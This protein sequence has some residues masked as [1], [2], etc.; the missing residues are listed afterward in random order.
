MVD[1]A[2]GGSRRDPL[3]ESDQTSRL[4]DPWP[5]RISSTI[6]WTILV[7]RTRLPLLNVS[8]SSSRSSGV[9]ET[10]LRGSRHQPAVRVSSRRGLSRGSGRN[11]GL[12]DRRVRSHSAGRAGRRLKRCRT[13]NFR[14]TWRRRPSA[15]HSWISCPD[16]RVRTGPG[17]GDPAHGLMQ[18]VMPPDVLRASI[19]VL[20]V[21][22]GCPRRNSCGG[23]PTTGTK[24]RRLFS[25]PAKSPAAAAFLT[26]FHPGPISR[27]ASIFSAMR[28]T[29]SAP[30]IRTRS[31]HTTGCVRF[32]S[33]PLLN[34]P[35]NACGK[36][37]TSCAG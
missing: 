32:A 1:L 23:S 6:C 8:R 16:R 19:R 22:T 7:L 26:S 5:F 9:S 29:P 21:A 18:I 37:P 13:S 14:L 31:D 4:G 12:R 24:R 33:C 28:S 30:S 36:P 2:A 20:R 15:L 25:S 34:F 3:I 10:R 35:W 27:F 11:L 17:P